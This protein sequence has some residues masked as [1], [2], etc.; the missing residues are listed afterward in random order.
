MSPRP[1]RQKRGF[2]LIELLLVMFILVVLAAIAAPIY[3]GRAAKSQIDAA[4]TQ[5]NLFETALQT[6]E[7]DVHSFPTDQQGLQALVSRPDGVD[8]WAPGGYLKEVPLDPWKNE[9]HYKNPGAHGT[10]D[11]WS[12]GPDK[13]DGTD[14]DIGNWS[15]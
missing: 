14:D 3:F 1:H 6:Y 9:Y 5:I 7:A 2:T 15:K 8:D 12:S 13:T 11:I 4:K 10:F